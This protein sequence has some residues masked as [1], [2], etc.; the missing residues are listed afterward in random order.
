MLRPSERLLLNLKNE[1][2]LQIVGTINAYTALLAMQSG[3]KCIYLSGAGVANASF[4][5]PDLGMTHFDDICI[6]AKRITNCVDIPLIVDLDSG[7]LHQA[8]A[9][10]I[11]N[12]MIECGVAAIQ[13]EDQ[14]IQ[15]RCGHRPGKKL[16]STKDMQLRIQNLKPDQDNKD[17]LIIARTDAYTV[18]G[19]TSSIERSQKYIESGADIIFAESF[20]SL[21]D[22]RMLCRELDAPVLANMT[23]FGLTPIYSLEQLYDSG[24]RLVLYPLS[25]FRAMN[26]AAEEVYESIRTHGHQ[27]H[28]IHKMQTRDE[29][30]KSLDYYR[31]ESQLNG[32][33]DDEL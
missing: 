18:E 9:S 3:F 24:V 27:K 25:A 26:R 20:N 4:G 19:L 7:F 32:D 21:D 15:K 14:V 22:Y 29:L 13:I 30:Y 5:I 23:E 1:T 16:V 31:Q 8:S 6:D 12:R 33:D 28:V 17:L 11:R 10:D 2:P